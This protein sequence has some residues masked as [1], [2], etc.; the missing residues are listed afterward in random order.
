MA[1]FIIQRFIIMILMLAALSLIVFITIELPPGD[2]ADRRALLDNI[3]FLD[4]RA[5]LGRWGTIIRSDHWR[6]D[7][8]LAGL[9]MVEIQAVCGARLGRGGSRLL[10]HGNR[11]T[12]GTPRRQIAL[13]IQARAISLDLQI[14]NVGLVEQLH[15]L[16]HCGQ[17]KCIILRRLL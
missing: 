4:I 11:N 14:G 17:R 9:K 7:C 13:D 10:R 15:D 2:Y 1:K 3:A 12:V 5:I 8:R 6:G 16:T